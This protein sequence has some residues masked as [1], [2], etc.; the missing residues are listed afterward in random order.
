MVLLMLITAAGISSCTTTRERE[1]EDELGEFRTWV[2][3]QSS[4][5]ANRTEADWKQ[6]KEDFR[7]RTQEL[8][9]KQEQFSQELQEEYQQLKQ[10]FT[11]ADEAYE[12][13]RSEARVAEWEQKLLGSWADVST[14]NETNV[15]DAYIN[16]LENVRAQKGNWSDEDWEMAK[17]VMEKLNERRKELTESI[18]TDSEVKIRALQME[19]RTLETAA[20]LGGN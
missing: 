13:S 8:D 20:D 16:F 15:R 2:N 6:A 17:L 12:R 19:F 14:I 1:V 11:E 9:Q 4:Q 7:M 5:I 3:G 10:E 18:D